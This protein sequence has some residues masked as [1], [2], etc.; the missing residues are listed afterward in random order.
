MICLACLNLLPHASVLS[1]AKV[2]S[3]ITLPSDIQQTVSSTNLVGFDGVNCK[4]FIKYH[5]N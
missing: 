3:V 2:L 4:V 5:Q 1:A